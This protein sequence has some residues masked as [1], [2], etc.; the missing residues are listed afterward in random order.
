MRATIKSII[1]SKT[2]IFKSFWFFFIFLIFSI[3]F[4]KIFLFWNYPLIWITIWTAFLRRCN[5]INLGVIHISFLPALASETL[6]PFPNKFYFLTPTLLKKL[7]DNWFLKKIC[8]NLNIKPKYFFL[9]FF[10]LDSSFCLSHRQFKFFIS[11]NFSHKVGC[12]RMLC[13]WLIG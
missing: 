7:S 2:A 13:L 3:T 5:L 8:E 1:C 12:T 4:F 11:M 9:I 6:F 10:N